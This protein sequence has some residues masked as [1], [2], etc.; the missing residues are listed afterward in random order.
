MVS[1]WD[2][3]IHTISL[4]RHKALVSDEA[5]VRGGIRLRGG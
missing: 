4:K 5:G 1:D 3:S 2:G